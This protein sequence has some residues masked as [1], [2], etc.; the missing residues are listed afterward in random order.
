LEWEEWEGGW[1]RTNM[2]KRHPTPK[3]AII[4]LNDENTKPATNPA[5]PKTHRMLWY[6][7]SDSFW[8]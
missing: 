5:T 8:P 6:S 4:R 3:M 7:S 2:E 1:Q